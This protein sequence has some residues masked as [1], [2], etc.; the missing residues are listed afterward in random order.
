[1]LKPTLIIMD[2]KLF[3]DPVSEDVNLS[4]LP[5]SAIAHSIYVNQEKMPDLDEMDLAII[6]VREARGVEGVYHKGIGKSADEVRKSLYQ[7]KKGTGTLKIIDLGNFRN[8]PELEDTYQRLREVC[9]YLMDQGILP[10]IVGGSH[11]LDLGQFMAYENQEKLITVLNVDNKLDLDDPQSALSGYSHIYQIFKY[12]PNYLFNYYQLAH[13][14]YLVETNESNLLE[15]LYFEAVRLGVVKENIKEMEP[16]VRDADMMTFDIS[17]IQ[18]HYCPGATDPKV[19]GLT[20]EE[21]CQICWYAGLNDKLSSIGFYGY[22]VEKDTGDRKTAFVMATMI[23]YFI[24]GFYSRKREKNFTSNDYLVYEVSLGGDPSSIKFYKS[25]VSEKWWM[26]VPHPIDA[27]SFMRSRMI[28]CSYS[29]YETALK[30][31]I[32]ERWITTYSKMI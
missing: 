22:D 27:T 5:S 6:G 23:W 31:E 20:G 3:F 21:A 24:E 26:E 4:G 1:M 2:L 32:P 16:I 25:K 28:P 19:Y 8:G 9:A 17:A 7:L 10:V 15:K 29:D 30:G 13:Q 18:A 11:D 12:D 14:S